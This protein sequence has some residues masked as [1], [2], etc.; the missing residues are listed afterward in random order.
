[1]DKKVGGYTVKHYELYRQYEG[2]QYFVV[3]AKNE[4]TGMWATWECTDGH[5]F[6]WGHY[7]NS[8]L[9]AWCDYHQRLVLKYTTP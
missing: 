9:E 5:D 2:R 1:M 3:L 4:K 8:E 6:Y 7:F